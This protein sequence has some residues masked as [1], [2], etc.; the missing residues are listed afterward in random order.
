MSKLES[1]G[2]LCVKYL[3]GQVGLSVLLGER[4]EV[5]AFGVVL[6]SNFP[7]IGVVLVPDYPIDMRWGGT[8]PKFFLMRC[9]SCLRLQACCSKKRD[10]RLVF[11]IVEDFILVDNRLI[12]T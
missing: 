8:S 7:G 11:E 10:C 9:S 3:R 2:P 12:I 5:K 6:V 1:F 4:P